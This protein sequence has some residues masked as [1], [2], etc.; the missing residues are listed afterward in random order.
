[1]LVGVARRHTL[2]EVWIWVAIE[3]WKDGKNRWVS[4]KYGSGQCADAVWVGSTMRQVQE[5]VH[6]YCA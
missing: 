4:R 2:F 1:M 6:V 5:Q 3:D